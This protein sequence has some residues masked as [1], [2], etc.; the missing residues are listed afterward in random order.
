MSK[1]EKKTFIF[2]DSENVGN[3]VP[4][5]LPKKCEV[6]FFLSDPHCLKSLAE[7]IGQ[8]HFSIYNISLSREAGVHK[9]EMDLCIVAS[10]AARLHELP[11]KKRAKT[12]FVILSKDK[13]YDQAIELLKES[14]D[15]DIVRE[16]MSL[17]KYLDGAPD[18][19][20]SVPELDGKF[21]KE[22]N[23]RKKAK[24]VR[25]WDL[26]R[27]SLTPSERKAIRLLE[28][29]SGEGLPVWFEYDFYSGQYILLYSGGIMGRFP[30]LEDA[31]QQ[32]EE[33]KNRGAKKKPA[34]PA[35]PVPVAQAAAAKKK[36]HRR[37]NHKHRP[38]KNP[39]AS[40]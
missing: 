28:A 21:P 29:Q 20:D 13:G 36:N 35:P 17:R 15:A 14:Y 30:A 6:C 7:L 4:D 27:K 11:A 18:P 8:K 40:Q 25:S 10:L 26:Y 38:Q 9:N 16:G 24:K 1:K 37:Y 3:L 5:A 22:K 39:A 34:R 32:Y 23:L 31:G 33:L 19:Y 12:R 2:V